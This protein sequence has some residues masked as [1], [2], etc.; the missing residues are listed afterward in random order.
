MDIQ[1]GRMKADGK[2]LSIDNNLQGDDAPHSLFERDVRLKYRKW[3]NVKHISEGF[4]QR[5]R[6]RKRKS[7]T[8]PNWGISI[9]TKER[10]PATSGRGVAF[11]LVVTLRELNG[12]NRIHEFMQLRRANN[13]FVTEVDIHVRQEIFEKADEVLVFDEER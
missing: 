9:K 8:S 12:I 13:W 10:L 7:Q 4:G 6:P 2:I 11:A 5:A 3:D 1:F